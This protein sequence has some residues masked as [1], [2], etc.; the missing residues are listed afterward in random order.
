MMMDKRLILIFTFIFMIIFMVPAMVSLAGT[1][2]EDFDDGKI[3]GWERSPQ[4]E[5]NNDIFWGVVDKSLMFDP[6]GQAWDQAISQLNFVGTQRI[7]NVRNWTDYELELDIKHTEPADWPGGF[8]ARVDL[9]TGGHYAVWFYPGAGKINLYKNPSW[10]INTGLVD[11]GNSPYKADV[12]KFHTAKLSC[13]GDT[14]KVFY[15]GKE[16]ISA[17]DSEHK[18]GTIAIDVQDKVVYFDNI[19]VT[20]TDIPNV[21]L[22][23]VQPGG[24]LTMTWGEI[25]VR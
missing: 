4:N 22:S 2:I 13:I 3:D 23:P 11:L 17:K 1:L 24:K 14:I 18:K 10:D 25:K 21:K 19:K 8:R 12:N 16:I 9:D 6:K 15:D 5:K 20:G 7:T